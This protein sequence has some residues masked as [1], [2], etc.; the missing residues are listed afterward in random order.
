MF[1][2][3]EGVLS[4]HLHVCISLTTQAHLALSVQAVFILFVP[5]VFLLNCWPD[6]P[7]PRLPQSRWED[8]SQSLN[9]NTY[10]YKPILVPIV[11]KS[12]SK[13]LDIFSFKTVNV[14]LN[15][16]LYFFHHLRPQVL[17]KGHDCYRQL[18]LATI[19]TPHYIIYS[20]FS[21]LQTAFLAKFSI[22][23]TLLFS[24]TKDHKYF[25]WIIAFKKRNLC[26][27]QI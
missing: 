23:F 19:N 1:L 22:M 7:Q 17:L 8:H 21:V 14:E 9:L 18:K 3:L 26:I 16:I 2:K 11:Y 12:V 13:L 4:Y 5:V 27:W 15:K 10:G 20:Q 24:I 6:W 25:Q